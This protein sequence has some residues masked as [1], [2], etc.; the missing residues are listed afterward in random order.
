MA[1]QSSYPTTLDPVPTDVISGN[2]VG[3]SAW[4][5]YL[6]GIFNLETKVGVNSSAV[7]G[8]VDYILNHASGT[9]MDHSARHE[10]GGADVMQITGLAGE[11]ASAQKLAIGKTTAGDAYQAGLDFT[12]VTGLTLSAQDTGSSTRILIG[13]SGGG[14]SA[15]VYNS[16]GVWSAP[17][18]TTWIKIMVWGGGGSG[19]SSST[20]AG[21]GGGGGG[22]Y[23]ERIMAVADVSQPV[24]ATIGA[25]GIAVAAG[26]NGNVG[27]T[28]SFGTYCY[29]YGGG[30]GGGGGSSVAG[31]GGGGGGIN[32][33]GS[34]AAGAGGAAGGAPTGGAHGVDSTLGGGGGGSSGEIGGFSGWGGAGGGTG[35]TSN[36]ETV[37]GNSYWGGAGG[38]G[39][40]DT[41][42]GANGGTSILG[43]SGGG[44]QTG[45]S[46]AAAGAQPGGGGG[47]TEAGNSGAGGAGRVLVLSW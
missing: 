39:G 45:G 28:S 24:T 9:L 41:G 40:S 31:G 20:G 21:G 16:T 6:D 30:G 42:V 12:P 38:G 4:N 14:A 11:A 47:G 22:A 19:G 35:T 36:T 13:G 17:T 46:N 33:A 37:G 7:A 1:N 26:N 18:G 5:Q 27:G 25:G 34:S 23:N 15:N 8:T 29:A 2:T 43:G 32:A 44:G 10:N 3:S